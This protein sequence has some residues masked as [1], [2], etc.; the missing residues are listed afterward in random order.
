MKSN[1]ITRMSWSAVQAVLCGRQRLRGQQGNQVEN[2]PVAYEWKW[3]RLH[4]RPQGGYWRLRIC[5]IQIDHGRFWRA[6]VLI[7][8]D[9]HHIWQVPDLVEKLETKGLRPFWT[10]INLHPGRPSAVSSTLVAK[11]TSSFGTTSSNRSIKSRTRHFWAI[12]F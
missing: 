4:R 8:A 3:S 5:D 11:R 1:R 6:P 2:T 7:V 10:K 9:W 12:F